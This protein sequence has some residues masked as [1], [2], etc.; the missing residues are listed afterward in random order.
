ME[1]IDVLQ[2]LVAGGAFVATSW[3]ASWGLEE[4]EWWH[5]LHS[6]ARS[7]IVLVISAV[8]GVGA[9][10]LL[11][12]PE[13]V[14]AL[15]PVFMPILLTIAAWLATQTVHK[16]AKAVEPRHDVTVVGAQRANSVEVEVD[17]PAYRGGSGAG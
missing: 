2:W 12:R 1:P 3:F 11:E 7:L 6:K 13:T 17:A 15:R 16:A 9:S 14:E 10:L 8:I 4:L 5:T